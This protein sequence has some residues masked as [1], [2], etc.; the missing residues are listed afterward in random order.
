ML[1][2]PVI[3][4]PYGLI[5]DDNNNGISRSNYMTCLETTKPRLV[6][7]SIKF[8][9]LVNQIS[10]LQ[11]HR[12]HASSRKV[13]NKDKRGTLEKLIVVVVIFGASCGLK[14]GT[15]RFVSREPQCYALINLPQH[16]LIS[17]RIKG[18][19]QQPL[20]E[21]HLKES[22]LLL[23]CLDI[24]LLL[25]FLLLLFQLSTLHLVNVHQTGNNSQFRLVD[26]RDLVQ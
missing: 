10:V 21:R 8:S 7:T 25:L 17:T 1:R 14:H 26:R 22:S 13:S 3:R 6:C 19:S 2:H 15:N 4:G 12:Q 24:L 18:Q 23:L 16:G 20:L 11:V 5:E 9:S